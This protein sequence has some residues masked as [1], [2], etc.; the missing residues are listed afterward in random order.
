MFKVDT[1]TGEIFIYDEIGPAWAGMIDDGMVIEALEQ[2]DGKRA[3]V[4]INSP[5]GFVDIGLG[6]VNALRRYE[7]GVD[8]VVDSLAASMASEIMLVGER[9]TIAKNAKVMIHLP[10]GGA[11]GTADEIL[12]I[13]DVFRKYEQAAIGNFAE[14]MQLEESQVRELLD[15]ETWYLGDEAVTAGLATDVG[16]GKPVPAVKVAANRFKHAPSDIVDE[17]LRIAAGMTYRLKPQ[18]KPKAE[19]TEI[20]AYHARQMAV[21]AKVKQIVK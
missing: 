13:V 12:S 21:S 16:L 18:E 5:G 15:A 20:H 2:L 9:R 4:R 19:P 3:L 1:T 6:I 17:G 7:G 11:Y 14:A 8:T 10:R